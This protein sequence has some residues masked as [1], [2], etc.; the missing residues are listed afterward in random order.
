MISGIETT[1]P[2]IGMV[3]LEALPGAPGFDGDRQTIREAMRRDA[4][5]LANGGVDALMIENFGDSP[6]YAADVPKH[7]VATMAT[8]VADI[9]RTV[10]LPL[11]VNVLR[12]DAE[13]AVSIA[14]ATGAS[15]VRVNVHTGT[16]VTDQGVVTGQAAETL[17][18]RD[19]LSA[20]VDIL[21]DVDV[22]HS[23]PVT[24]RPLSEEVVDLI[25]RGHA[26]GII[27]TGAGTGR[28]TD[29]KQLNAI[30]EAQN[31]MR[32]DIPVLVGSGVTRDTAAETLELADGIIVG[33]DLKQDG[34]TAA[35]VDEQRVRDLV[36]AT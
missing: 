23:A 9:R 17:R 33:S 7:T 24:E 21:A 4:R 22:K 15:F 32:T 31:R 27:V 26:D 11:G 14:A 28:E 20:E 13:A 6:F 36:A 19:R 1:K 34:N 25:E 30:I 2:I 35:P 5:R 3:H 8:L 18:L 12:N 16:R 10:E 29:R